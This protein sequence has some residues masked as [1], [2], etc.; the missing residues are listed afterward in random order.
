MAQYHCNH[1]QNDFFLL[2]MN[3]QNIASQSESI[4]IKKVGAIY[5]RENYIFK[6]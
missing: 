1:F 6:L 4:L 5:I 3:N 2:M